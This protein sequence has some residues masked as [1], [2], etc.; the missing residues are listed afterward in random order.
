MLKLYTTRIIAEPKTVTR[1]I[2]IP[3]NIFF[4]SKY[5][6]KSTKQKAKIQD[7]QDCNK[8]Y[9]LSLL[10]GQ[11]NMTA[12]TTA[13]KTITAGVSTLYSLRLP[14]FHPSANIMR[15]IK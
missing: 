12:V 13:L 15:N 6:I 4:M 5:R 11:R 1:N 14:K 7:D 10:V 3:F 8:I 2:K 9:P